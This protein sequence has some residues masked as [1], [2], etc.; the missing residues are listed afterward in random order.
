MFDLIIAYK[1]H[2]VFVFSVRVAFISCP[3][4]F[5]HFVKV[6]KGAVDSVLLEYDD[7]F[8]YH[9]NNFI[10]YDYN[11]PLALPKEMKGQFEIVVADPPFLS[12]EC[13]SKFAVTIKF[14]ARDKVLLCTGAVMEELAVRLLGVKPCNFQPKHERNLGNDFK[15]YVNFESIL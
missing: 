3:T 14:L 4:L 7:R 12:E 2:D 1:F 6:N 11:E 13:L 5:N 9:G 15:C 8:G 10:K